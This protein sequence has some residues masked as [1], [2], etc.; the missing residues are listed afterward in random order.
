MAV[1]GDFVI[2]A[3]QIRATSRRPSMTELEPG[4]HEHVTVMAPMIF[5]T[6]DE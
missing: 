2:D 5:K 6:L 4:H 1:S 3:R